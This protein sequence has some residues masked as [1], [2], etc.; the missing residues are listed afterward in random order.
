MVVICPYQAQCRAMLARETGVS[1]QTV[2]SLQGREADLVIL[3]MVRTGSECGFWKDA[4][5][6][7]VA[8]TRAKHR[9][10]IV[11]SFDWVG[12]PLAHLT[13]DATARD[14]LQSLDDS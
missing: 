6:L 5:R 8:L 4:R 7:V 10:Y 2:D 1:V 3:S 12:E 13:R 11:G 14:V 9:L